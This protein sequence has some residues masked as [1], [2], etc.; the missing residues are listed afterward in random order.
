MGDVYRARDL[1]LDRDVAIK[2]LPP[3][4]VNNED[5]VRRFVQEAKAASSLNHP[6]IVTVYEIGK[7]HQA[8]GSA[9]QYIAMELIDGE[10]LRSRI[11]SGNRNLKQM[12]GYAAQAADALA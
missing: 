1:D 10:T 4:V 2:V 6:H 11:Q 7:A 8:D 5:R 3:D 9:V 12:L